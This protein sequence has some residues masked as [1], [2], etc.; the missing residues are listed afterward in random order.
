MSTGRELRDLLME[1]GMLTPG[2]ETAFETVPRHLFLPEVMWPATEEGH[3]TVSKADDPDGWWHW[4]DADVPIVTQWDDGRHTG[5]APGALATSSSSMPTAV[6]LMFDELSVFDGAR[7]LEI[8]T[9]TGWCA[10]LLSARLG[11]A[12]V[13]SVEIDET[14]ADAARKALGVAGWY[15]EV[16]TGD[17]LL[18]WPEGAPYDRILVTVG[19]HEV[20]RA[21][22]EQTRPGGVIVMPWGTRYSGQNAIVRLVVADDGTASGRFS[23]ATRFMHV[24]SQRLEWPE[25]D[26]YLPGEGWPADTRS[27]TTDLPFAQIADES[28]YAASDFA[29]SLLVPD[30]VRTFA[31]SPQGV[32]TM[33]LYGLADRSWAAVYFDEDSQ[34]YQG[35]PRNLW[36]EV[37]TAHRWWVERGRPG[38]EEFGLTVTA[39]GRQEVWLGEPFTPVPHIVS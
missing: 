13:T 28:D 25:F 34:V 11:E 36:D 39:D 35:G 33:W 22:I 6:L 17:G 1:T 30:C 24:R 9:G 14:V 7:A 38:H 29:I 37:E 8:G 10:A 31:R 18:G 16:V 32:Q 19:V 26:D 2:W 3:I 20:P 27:S 15:P 21:W 23:R 12:N 5:S 4:A